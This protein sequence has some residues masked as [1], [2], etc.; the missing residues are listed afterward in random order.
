MNDRFPAPSTVLEAEGLGRPVAAELGYELLGCELGGGANRPVLRYFIEAAGG[1]TIDD[2]VR[3]HKAVTD[4]LDAE[5]LFGGRW[6]LEVSSPGLS[7]PLFRASHLK[8][9]V[10]QR[11]AVKLQVGIDGRRRATGVLVEADEQQARI[12]TDDGVDVEFALND[13]EKAHLVWQG[14]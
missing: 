6:Q 12:Q 10:G 3:F 11:V 7:R 1:T 2:C 8:A 5:E 14:D 4:L 13:V 9:V